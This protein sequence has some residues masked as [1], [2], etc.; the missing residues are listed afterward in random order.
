MTGSKFLRILTV[1]S[2]LIVSFGSVAAPLNAAP[3]PETATGMWGPASNQAGCGGDGQVF[4]VN[5]GGVILFEQ[6]GADSFVVFDP[7]DWIA[8]TLILTR[9][10]GDIILPPIATLTK[11]ET[12]PGQYD[13]FFG[14]AIALFQGFDDVQSRCADGSAKRCVQAVFDMFDVS[15]D[16]RLSQAEISRALRAGAFFFGYESIVAGRKE[17]TA[18][19][20]AWELYGVPV[21]EI[22]GA[23]LAAALLGPFFTDN[24]IQSYDFDADG[25]LSMS[26]ILQ[27]RGADSLVAVGGT[28]GSAAAQT[29]LQGLISMVQGLIGGL[30]PGFP[31]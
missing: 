19:T 21:N 17:L 3:V 10:A 28:F 6:K 8:G 22:Y 5:S 11:C 26:E 12:L 23:A 25:V 13:A 16:E 14:D 4:L 15:G 9:Q 2:A 27:D 29:G 31:F 18:K 1:F 30:M 24:L 7:V 20:D